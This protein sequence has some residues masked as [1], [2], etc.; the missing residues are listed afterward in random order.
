MLLLLPVFGICCW[1]PWFKSTESQNGRGWKGPL[2]ISQSP[3]NSTFSTVSCAGKHLKR[4]LISPVCAHYPLSC[5]CT[6]LK[7]AWHHSFDCCTSN[8]YKQWWA[9]TL[10]FSPGWTVPGFSAFPRTA[11]APGSPLSLWS[12]AGLSLDVVSLVWTEE[13][14]TR[15]SNPL[16]AP[17]GQRREG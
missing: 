16:M 12:S 4:S 17:P 7:R 9:P 1:E 10:S 11:D 15:H 2:A 6:P 14:G 8:I 5:C 3:C 13:L